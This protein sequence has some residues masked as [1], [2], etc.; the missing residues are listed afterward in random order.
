MK[1]LHFSL[2]DLAASLSSLLIF[3]AII[4]S[5]IMLPSWRPEPSYRRY[6]PRGPA[7]YSAFGR[8]ANNTMDQL[9]TAQLLVIDKEE[10]VT[11]YSFTSGTRAENVKGKL[12]TG[13]TYIL[14]EITAPAGYKLAEDVEFTVAN[15]GVT[16]VEMTDAQTVARITKVK[17][18]GTPEEVFDNPKDSRLKE[19]LS[20]L[21]K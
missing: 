2:R 17:E 5:N 18:D 14:R 9:L 7:A 4:I 21:K 12:E 15:S 8:T 6:A 1:V 10:D 13:K 11:V 16:E 3:S 19:F 20:A